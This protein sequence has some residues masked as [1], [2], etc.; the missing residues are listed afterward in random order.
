MAQTNQLRSA[1]I[2][3]QIVSTQLKSPAENQ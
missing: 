2:D 1:Q 3:M